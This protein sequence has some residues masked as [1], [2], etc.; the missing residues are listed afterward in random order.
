MPDEPRREATE[1]KNK[2]T[3]KLEDE[4]VLL[5]TCVGLDHP[6]RA[7]RSSQ[8]CSRVGLGR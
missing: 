7:W 2:E 3:A 1:I 6:E 5:I 4:I 8:R